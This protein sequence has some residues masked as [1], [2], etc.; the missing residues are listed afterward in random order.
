MVL[1]GREIQVAHQQHH[2]Q[3]QAQPDLRQGGAEQRDIDAPQGEEHHEGTNHQLRLSLPHA[4]IGLPVVFFHNRFHI[5]GRTGGGVLRRSSVYGSFFTFF[6]KAH[7]AFLTFSPDSFTKRMTFRR[8]PRKL[9]RLV[10]PTRDC[11][12]HSPPQPLGGFYRFLTV[13]ERLTW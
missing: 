6:P 11:G 5:G 13:P 9:I 12:G 8:F 2:A 10:K 3:E 7:A 1:P 4:G